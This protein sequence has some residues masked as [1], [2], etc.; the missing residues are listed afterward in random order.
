MEYA[1]IIIPTLNREKHLKRCITSLLKNKEAAF[2]D[3]YISVDFPPSE[4]F[5]NGYK[6]VKDYVKTI[7][8]FKNVYIYF[9]EKNLG[10]GL[11]SRFLKEKISEKHDKYIFTE[12][13]NE[14]SDNFLSYMNWGLEEYKNDDNIYAICSCTD[15]KI[16]IN[17]CQADYFMINSYNPYGDGFWL[18]KNKL[19]FDYLK[20]DPLSAIYNSKE[21]QSKLYKQFPK[22]YWWVARDCLRKVYEMR[23]NDDSLTYI[24]IWENVYLIENNLYCIKPTIPKSRNWGNDGSG[25]HGGT[26]QIAD[27]VPSVVLDESEWPKKPVRMTEE[28][29]KYVNSLFVK[30]KSISKKEKI[31]SDCIF[32]LNKF[33]GNRNLLMFYNFLRKI[34]HTIFKPNKDNNEV[35]KYG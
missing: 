20:N 15:F 13:D 27:Y 35:I 2:T 28:D 30:E 4:K 16:D 18:H 9:Q 25:V 23:G 22:I 21:K 24:D 29:E 10:P 26:D 31:S 19:C 3:L 12:D 34:Y 5:E 11:N 32:A 33:F 1:A 7:N 14:F 17:D 6:E 8:G